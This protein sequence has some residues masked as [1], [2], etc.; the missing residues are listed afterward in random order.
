[1]TATNLYVAAGQ[2]VDQQVQ[3]GLLVFDLQTHPAS[4]VGSFSTGN[5][6]A[7]ALAI[8]GNT[9]FVGAG[10]STH[11]LH[12]TTPASPTEIGTINLG[13]T[14]LAVAGNFLFAATTDNHLLVFEISNIAA[15]VQKAVIALPDV[16]IQM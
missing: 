3:G 14:A 5:S 9:L 4:F 6:V 12:I 1:M 11:I 2:P 16:A 10:D 13:T 8:S 15:P 7:Q